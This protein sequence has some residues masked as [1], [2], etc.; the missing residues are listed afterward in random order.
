MKVGPWPAPTAVRTLVLYASFAKKSSLTASSGWALFHASMDFWSTG[1]LPP[2]RPNMV[3]ES[4]LP[5][6]LAGPLDP[7]AAREIDTA[8]AVTAIAAERNV[9]F[10]ICN[11]IRP[12]GSTLIARLCFRE[13]GR[14]GRGC[15][16]AE[17]A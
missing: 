5:A 2:V 15:T 3:A 7:Q 4:A 12:P 13:S 17:Y 10:T 11:S 1:W 8:A 14:Q 6:E 9:S 16:A